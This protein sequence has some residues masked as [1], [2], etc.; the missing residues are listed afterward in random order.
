MF[1]NNMI[2]ILYL[3]Y[4]VLLVFLRSD[5]L[6][7]YSDGYLPSFFP[8]PST[9]SV[10]FVREPIIISICWFIRFSF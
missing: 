3:C 8:C 6:K 4:K 5:L 7:C 9:P 2:Y 10:N 1:E